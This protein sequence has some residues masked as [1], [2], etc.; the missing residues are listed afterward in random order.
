MSN[1]ILN[2][3]NHCAP[4]ELLF[5]LCILYRKKTAH[6]SVA[7]AAELQRSSRNQFLHLRFEGKITPPTYVIDYGF[8]LQTWKEVNF[9]YWPLF[10]NRLFKWR[11][12][13]K[14]ALWQQTREMDAGLLLQRW[15]SAQRVS[16]YRGIQSKTTLWP[17]ETKCTSGHLR[18]RWRCVHWSTQLD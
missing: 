3:H 11:K 16:Y 10:N 5:T 7:Q 12:K 4:L 17:S 15:Q 1:P 14:A 2:D 9:C 13:K 6:I 8:P 18:A